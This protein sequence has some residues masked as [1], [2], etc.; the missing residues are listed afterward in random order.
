MNNLQCPVVAQRIAEKVQQWDKA[1]E[2]Y[3][4][5]YKLTLEQALSS[6]G[7][8]KNYG[9]DMRNY[10]QNLLEKVAL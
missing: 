8:D 3:R 1:I 10:C 6:I 5:T 7:N 2:V 4:E 9:A